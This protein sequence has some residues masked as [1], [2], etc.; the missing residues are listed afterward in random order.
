M[1]I[2]IYIYKE[3]GGICVCVGV[4]V[5]VLFIRLIDREKVREKEGE[6]I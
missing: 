3:R 2:Y 1:Y 4:F 6:Q 5:G